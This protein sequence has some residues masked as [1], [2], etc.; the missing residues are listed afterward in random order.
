MKIVIIGGAGTT[1]CFYG[2]VV[3]HLNKVGFHKPESITILADS[4]KECAILLEEKL[5]SINEDFILLGHSYGGLVCLQ[6]LVSG[7]VSDHIKGF[8]MCNS[9]NDFTHLTIDSAVKG[10][11]TQEK[12]LEKY[13]FMITNYRHTLPLELKQKQLK[14]CILNKISS[15]DKFPKN[16]P[17]YILG[18]SQD[19]YLKQK[20]LEKFYADFQPKKNVSLD[21]VKGC[22]HL[23]IVT[24][25][26]DYVAKISH[27]Y[28]H[29]I[30]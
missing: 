13:P 15:L 6:Y 10:G 14:I 5:V 4:L 9:T 19:G 11:E 7:N 17:V 22:K 28:K 25:P 18:S 8:I 16:I 3:K 26:K 24:H 30:E 27:W 20:D 21:F 2:D 29:F 12:Y 1:D 23:G